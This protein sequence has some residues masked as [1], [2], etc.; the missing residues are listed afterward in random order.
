MAER[1]RLDAHRID[2]D[3]LRGGRRGVAE[4]RVELAREGGLQHREQLRHRVGPARE[5]G[6]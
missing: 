2:L 3:F 6:L 4:R 5:A 1:A